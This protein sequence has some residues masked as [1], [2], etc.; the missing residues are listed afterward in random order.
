M[1]NENDNKKDFRKLQNGVV[2]IQTAVR[3]SECLILAVY[4]LRDPAADMYHL[5]FTTSLDAS[6][7]S[8][9]AVYKTYVTNKPRKT[10]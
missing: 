8:D 6:E 9:P 3:D 10:T 5:F 4:Y 1:L 7:I 2:W